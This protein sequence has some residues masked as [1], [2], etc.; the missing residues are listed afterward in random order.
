MPVVSW[1]SDLLHWCR[2]AGGAVARV[3]FW[4]T[5][6]LA[7][8][9][10]AAWMILHWGILPHLERWKPE[11]Q[12]WASRSL[13]VD[14]RLGTLQASGGIWAPVVTLRD[15]RI[16]DARG[17]EALRLAKVE[18]VFTPGSLWPRSPTRWLPHVQRLELDTLHLA[19][20][21][22]PR[23][24]IFLAGLALDR[25]D[26][27]DED[28]RV[29]DWLFSQSE[30][31]LRQ[32]SLS[33]QDEQR[34]TE[35]LVL[36]DVDLDLR[37]P[38]GRHVL[39]LSATPPPGWGSR[40]FASA[41]MARPLR[42][43]LSMSGLQHPGDWRQWAGTAQAEWPLVDVSR[44][45]RHV[46]LPFD[47]LEGRGRLATRIDVAQG[48]LTGATAD[49]QL[50]AVTLRVAKGLPPVALRRIAGQL[51]VRHGREGS[52]VKA[53]RLSFQSQPP[54]GA[55]VTSAAPDPSLWPA[56]DLELMLRG[57]PGA[58]TGGAFKASLVDL[59]LLAQSAAHVPLAGPMRR[60]LEATQPRGQVRQLAYEWSGDVE[61]PEH[62]RARGDADALSLVAAPATAALTSTA[63]P[64]R[65]GLRGGRVRF[66]A[67]E[68]GGQA[69]LRIL[70]GE[71]EFP[72]VFEQPQVALDQF[73][74]DVRWQ[75]RQ[76]PKAAPGARPAIDVEVRRAVFATADG[77][78]EFSGHWRSGP[79]GGPTFGRKGWLPGELDLDATVHQIRA[80]RIHRYLP[81]GIHASVRDYVREAVRAGSAHTVHARVRGSV[82]DFPFTAPGQG[83]FAIGG[84]FEQLTLD[85]VPGSR[86]PRY[87]D[88]SGQLVI[89]G[90]QLRLMQVRARLGE[91]GSG[92]VSLDNIEGG[93]DHLADT[94]V[95]RLRGQGRGS[96]ADV[97]EFLRASPI[98]GW[99]GHAFTP[100]K[101][102]GRSQLALQLAIPLQQAENT[103]VQGHVEL[104]DTR[105]QMR[106]DTPALE[107][108][109][110]RLDFTEHSFRLSRGQAQAA[111][112]PLMFEGHLDD[113]GHLRFSGQGRAT[114]QGLRALDTVEPLARLAH[115]FEGETDYRLQLTL[116]AEGPTVQVDSDL[117][118]LASHL[119]A[120]LG[121]PA[122][123]AEPLRV[124]LEP[125]TPAAATLLQ[126]DA[127]TP[128]APRLHARLLLDG[129]HEDTLRG[130]HVQVGAS[131]GQPWPA[132]GLGVSIGLPRLS[133]DD[134]QDW[135][136]QAARAGHLPTT[137]HGAESAA[138]TAGD[139][140]AAVVRQVRLQVADLTLH[141]RRL[142]QVTARLQPTGSPAT[143]S[144]DIEAE[145]LAG[146]VMLRPASALAPA[147]TQARL[148]RLAL[149][150]PTDPLAAVGRDLPTAGT[151]PAEP[152]PALD[153]VVDDL[154]V[155]GR[156][157]GRLVLQGIPDDDAGHRTPGTAGA[158]Q[159]QQL[160]LTR[161]EARLSAS[162]RWDPAEREEM[163]STASGAGSGSSRLS[164]RL[165]MDDGGQWLDQLG[166]AGTLRGGRG[167]ISGQLR[168]PGPP[169]ALA[170][171]QLGGQLR[172]DVSSGQLLQ[173]DPG[174]AGRLLGV[175]NLQSLPR[176]LSLDFRDL[177]QKGFSFDHIDG[178]VQIR[179]GQASTHNL[180]V[181]GVQA[182]VLAE[183]SASL[184]AATQNLRVWVV[185]DFNAGAASLAYAVINP[186]I[187]L[188]TLVTQWLLQRPLA[189]AAT[190]EFQVTGRWD[191]PLVTPVDRA[192]D[193]RPLPGSAAAADLRMAED[194]A[195]AAAPPDTPSASPALPPRK[196][197]LP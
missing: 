114:A 43:L 135:L 93:I 66:D 98:D 144:G 44:L 41:E 65:P 184:S 162:G 14:V 2:R 124:R 193:A 197:R 123:Q 60:L 140:L 5:T 102:D 49:L 115:A 166:W 191:A 163:A 130:G 119:P 28:G 136:Q 139:G 137:G 58:W 13:G 36:T 25:S 177:Y 3:A 26:A 46:D 169:A 113:R 7:T 165:E 134:W 99:L 21:R 143:W 31:R 173:A 89:D 129:A 83:E 183:G 172:L 95:L 72:G 87:T 18:A 111:G 159:L 157:L 131:D 168:W 194:A 109:Q 100:A 61:R 182:V 34:G 52:T 125:Q 19:L 88:G 156:H 112:G 69:D 101:G 73:K 68:R 92:S 64:G 105:L 152:M 17:Q 74:A 55:T 150:W 121:K 147:A 104:A 171:A 122:A 151:A 128:D 117:V 195:I 59:G 158:W 196:D 175:L 8:L 71:L 81:L 9:T 91:T 107:Q 57:E 170:M 30:I 24:Q 76:A 80:D 37:N 192:Q 155:R 118:G 108:L 42:T 174:G 79:P 154:V 15:L 189:E 53:R 132:Q 186:A 48:R 1:S 142:S 78:G 35:P 33:W 12:A 181:R 149:P 116:A 180:R 146:R 84:R 77:D 27:A 126:I 47:L 94:P 176:R 39:R 22:D 32:S 70:R 133:L 190:R 160:S 75:L 96:T 127:G 90:Q 6:A 110:A 85:A 178:D 148:S 62:W 103:T 161:P 86:W 51:E 167:Q 185:P 120:P 23:G 141:G 179:H 40:F 11:L 188:G 145:Q 97:L 82:L 20:R 54:P 67:T 187:G 153:L 45:R 138:G 16:V 50:E 106:P 29:A 10:L 56:T 63:T 38:L 4:S 164:F